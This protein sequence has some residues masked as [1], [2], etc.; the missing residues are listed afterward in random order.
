MCPLISSVQDVLGVALGLIGRVGE[1]DAAGLHPA[2]GQHLGLDHDRA[3]DLGSAICR[4]SLWRL[5]EAVLGDGNARLGHDR[6]GLVLEEAHRRRGSLAKRGRHG[7]LCTR[8]PHRTSA[9]IP[10]GEICLRRNEYDK[11]L[12]DKGYNSP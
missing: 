3:V 11:C 12:L 8:V 9:H 6:P 5:R 10:N 1:L 7:V 4:A 2:A